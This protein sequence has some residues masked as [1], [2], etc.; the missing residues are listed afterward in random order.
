MFRLSPTSRPEDRLPKARTL[1]Q[2]ANKKRGLVPNSTRV[3][4]KTHL[5][6]RPKLA[7][8]AKQ[9]VRFTELRTRQQMAFDNTAAL[10]KEQA[11]ARTL[12]EKKS[13]AEYEAKRVA[14]LAKQKQEQ[15]ANSAAMRHTHRA[16]IQMPI[17]EKRQREKEKR[18]KDLDLNQARDKDRRLFQHKEQL[19]DM[20]ARKKQIDVQNFNIAIES[21][22][23]G[24]LQEQNAAMKTAK[25]DRF[26]E[27]EEAERQSDLDSYLTRGEDCRLLQHEE[28]LKAMKNREIRISERN[29]DIS[30]ASEIH[31]RLQ[32]ENAA[33]K[34]ANGSSFLKPTAKAKRFRELQT[35]QKIVD[36]LALKKECE[37]PGLNTPSPKLLPVRKGLAFTHSLEGSNYISAG[38]GEPH[39]RLPEHPEHKLLSLRKWLALDHSLEES[40]YISSGKGEPHCRLTEHPEHKL[41]SL[42]KGLAFNHSL[43]GSNYISSGKEP[44]CRL[45]KLP[46]PFRAR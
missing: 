32:E 37:N 23:R 39:C 27:K 22:K 44:Q 28:Q 35:R 45:S 11:T 34:T 12:R 25:A 3:V 41:L 1:M 46:K 38:K 16:G 7:K 43:E 36:N 31:L 10:Q 20:K 9:A 42:R 17:Q 2:E 14:E 21:E 15:Q 26:T 24:R 8:Q 30:I 29:F 19:K 6:E 4:V 13:L 33:K 5:E 40:N 18:Q